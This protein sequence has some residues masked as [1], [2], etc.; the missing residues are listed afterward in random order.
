MALGYKA[1]FKGIRLGEDRPFCTRHMTS[2]G[3]VF[4]LVIVQDLTSSGDSVKEGQRTNG[5]ILQ[6]PLNVHTDHL[7]IL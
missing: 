7:G 2:S 1:S 6:L 5:L 4:V 3:T